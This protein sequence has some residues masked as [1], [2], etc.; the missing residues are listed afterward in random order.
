MQIILKRVNKFTKYAKIEYLYWKVNNNKKAIAQFEQKRLVDRCFYGWVGG[1]KAVL[2]ITNLQRSKIVKKK[3]KV[4][5]LQ[6]LFRS[7]LLLKKIIKK[8]NYTYSTKKLHWA[9]L[10]TTH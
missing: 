4:K 5:L 9:F 7:V 3:K 8:N 2:R 6:L 10:T 1:L